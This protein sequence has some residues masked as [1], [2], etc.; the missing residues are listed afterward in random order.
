MK[1]SLKNVINSLLLLISFVLF[2]CKENKV[3]V[4]LLIQAQK[5]ADSKPSDA[6]VLLD[7]IPN[8]ENLDK[9]NYMQYIVTRTQARFKN[10]QDISN[11]TLIFEAQNYFDS[12]NDPHNSALAHFYAGN[13]YYKRDLPDK[14]LDSY[15]NAEVYARSSGDNILTGKSLYNIGYQYYNQDVI[16]S[17]IVHYNQAL[18]CFDQEPDTDLLKMQLLYSLG[19][20]YFTKEDIDSAFITYN[21]GLELATKLDNPK[22]LTIFVNHLGVAL[23][24]KGMYK[25]ASEKLHTSLGKVTSTVDSLRIYLNL[26]ILHNRTGGLDS[27]QFYGNLITIRLNEISN[28]YVLRS[29]YGALKETY[30]MQRNYAEAL[31]YTDLHSKTNQEIHNE[32]QSLELLVADKNF[33]L[34]QKEKQHA[35]YIGQVRYWLIVGGGLLLSLLILFVFSFRLNKK[36]K[37]E[38]SLQ[39]EKYDHLKYR[40]TKMSYDT[41]KLEA[42]LKSILD[43]NDLK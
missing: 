17:A 43:D 20:A 4:D 15:L 10:G 30:K 14:A 7:S 19:S 41:D 12:R 35:I 9:D 29:V 8:P 2:S 39:V 22:Y 1:Y 37:K 27:A 5:I 16:D 3:T 28:K 11:D 13:V 36:H 25:E 24:E 31:R 23:G 18:A 6:L 38:Y 42:E 33:G 32:E 21:K 40:L 34:N 26:S